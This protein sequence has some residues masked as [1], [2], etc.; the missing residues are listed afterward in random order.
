MRLQCRLRRTEACRSLNKMN[1]LKYKLFPL[2]GILLFALLFTFYR[3]NGQSDFQERAIACCPVKIGDSAE[4]VRSVMGTGVTIG[5]PGL[6]PIHE[7]LTHPKRIISNRCELFAIPKELS[8]DL[9]LSGGYF[10]YF[11]HNN[12]VEYIF[13]GGT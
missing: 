6:I 13:F 11:D 12:T 5:Q 2:A 7:G 8:C 9:F 4:H 3:R 1:A 10:V